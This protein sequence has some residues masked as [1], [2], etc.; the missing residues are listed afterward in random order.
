MDFCDGTQTAL[1][2]RSAFG[3]VRVY[4]LL[5]REVVDTRTTKQFQRELVKLVRQ[6]VE[7]GR[8][9]WSSCLSTAHGGVFLS[10]R[11]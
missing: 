1:L 3:L 9:N 4:N 6:E 11:R 8:P 10:R 2:A 5:P 7:A